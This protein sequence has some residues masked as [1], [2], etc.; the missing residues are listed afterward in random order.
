M[1]NRNAWLKQW[2]ERLR[3]SLGEPSQA[4]LEGEI[5][6]LLSELKQ[7]EARA[8]HA[9]PEKPDEKSGAL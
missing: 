1:E 6:R 9:T 7:R 5:G 8:P 4:P 2:G 3:E